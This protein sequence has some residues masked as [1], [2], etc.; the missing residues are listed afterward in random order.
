MLHMPVGRLWASSRQG[1]GKTPSRDDGAAAYKRRITV[2]NSV[3]ADTKRLRKTTVLRSLCFFCCKKQGIAT[4]GC[5][6]LQ[7]VDALQLPVVFPLQPVDAL[8]P[9]VCFQLQPLVVFGKEKKGWSNHPF[10]FSTSVFASANAVMCAGSTPVTQPPDAPRRAVPITCP[11]AYEA[12]EAY[13]ARGF[14]RL[15]RNQVSLRSLILALGRFALENGGY[16]GLPP[17]PAWGPVPRP[18][19]RFAAVKRGYFSE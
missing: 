15:S 11:Q 14:K 12:Y 2:P 5:V 6:Q 10:S 17:K 19:L 9:W 1:R 18:H 16:L 4:V 3:P 7:L 8:Q 13:E